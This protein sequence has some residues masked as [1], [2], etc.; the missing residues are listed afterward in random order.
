MTEERAGA[1]ST[2]LTWD[3]LEQIHQLAI[4]GQA[5]LNTNLTTPHIDKA[6]AELLGVIADLSADA[7]DK[8]SV[9]PRR[10]EDASGTVGVATIS[11]WW[12]L[13]R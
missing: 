7:A 8:C 4:T 12:Y 3:R 2:A 6:V 13:P 5:A 1:N 10:N 9:E 11:Q